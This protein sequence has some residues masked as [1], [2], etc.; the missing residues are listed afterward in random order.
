[1][2]GSWEDI[3]S[4]WSDGET[5]D[6]LTKPCPTGRHDQSSAGAAAALSATGKALGHFEQH[7]A[8]HSVLAEFH[9]MKHVLDKN[10]LRLM[11]ALVHWTQK[12]P[13]LELLKFSQGSW[14]G[15]AVWWL[16]SK[17]L[18]ASIKVLINGMREPSPARNAMEVQICLQVQASGRHPSK[19]LSRVKITSHLQRT[20]TQ[21]GITHITLLVRDI[22]GAFLYSS[23]QGCSWFC[24]GFKHAADLM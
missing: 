20:R 8:S 19:D 23:L 11:A 12:K 15:A 10:G 17:M 3:S 21:E 2:V 22:A 16:A 1:M 7:G 13:T 18:Y 9:L 4:I 6:F 24:C 14:P 5:Q